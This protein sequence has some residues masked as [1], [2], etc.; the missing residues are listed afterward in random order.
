[1]ASSKPSSSKSRSSNGSKRSTSSEDAISLLKAD[2]RE[3]EKLFEEYQST[4]DSAGKAEIAQQ[5]CQELTIHA[6]IEEEIFYPACREEDIEEDMLD[7]AQVEHD[8]AKTL[9]LELEA[10]SPDDDFY[11]AKVMVLSEMIKHHVN[12]EEKRGGIFT[13]ARQ[14]DIDLEAMGRALKERKQSLMSEAESGALPKPQM[15][16]MMHQAAAAE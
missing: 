8:G 4:D 10:G 15:P 7:E 3:V 9:I 16:S 5:I 13:K 6:M 12:E 1:M 11:D 14:S 2:H